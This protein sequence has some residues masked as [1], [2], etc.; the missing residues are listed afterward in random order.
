MKVGIA[1]AHF[2]F[3]VTSPGYYTDL[4]MSIFKKF[5][6]STIM[7]GLLEWFCG[8][9]MYGSKALI[10]GDDSIGNCLKGNFLQNYL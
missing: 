7:I 5:S 8:K 6:G 1:H 4:I 2:E 9:L 10:M 3:I